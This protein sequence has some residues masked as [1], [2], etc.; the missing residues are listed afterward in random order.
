LDYRVGV[1]VPGIY[2]EIFNSDRPEYGGSGIYN[3]GF[4]TAEQ[5]L[6]DHREYSLPLQLPPL[7]VVILKTT[8]G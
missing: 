4:M 2:K 8:V 3:P 1:P 6:C 5:Y 7:A